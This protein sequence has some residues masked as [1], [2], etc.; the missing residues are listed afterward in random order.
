MKS[1]DLTPKQLEAQ[2]VLAGDAT[3]IMLF[4]G[5]RSGKTFLLVR[6]VV[7]RALKAPK[8]RHAILRFRFNAIKASIVYDTFPKVMEIA[9]PGVPHELNKTDWFAEFDN[10]SQ[11]WFGGL[12][13]KE[14]TEKIL[15]QEYATIYLNETSQIPY[16]SRETAVTRLAQKAEQVIDG[17]NPSP[18]KPRMYYDCNPPSKA[19]WTYKLFV[20]KADPDSKKPLAN[21]HDYAYF[22]IN[23]EDNAE[24]ISA[25]Y[26][27]T[28][29]SLSAAKRRRFLDGQFTDATPNQLFSEDTIEKW[30]HTHGNLPDFVRVVVGVDPSGSGDVE[31]ADN[32]AIGIIV[33]AIGTDGNAYLLEDCTVKAGP[34]TWGSVAVNAYDR[35]ESDALVGEVNYGG[36]MVEHTI[37]VARKNIGGR[38]CNYKSVNATRG[39]V[40]RA[41]PFSALYEQG[42]VRHVG[43][44]PELEEEMAAFS[45]LGYMGERSPNRA[46]AW[47]WV[48]T[49]LFPGLVRQAKKPQ[50]VEVLPTAHRWK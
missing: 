18:L 33:G 6:N 12:D 32:D 45:T 17:R 34:A 24:N 22:Q 11:I 26:L 39:K 48:L 19:H 15:G 13:D 30:R 44:Y 38:S 1:F 7:M 27:E 35:H 4:G 2:H 20:Q 9:F 40:I 37:Q 42:K 50:N 8:S 23:P 31:N 10:G 3:H 16:G 29:Q 21:P 14:R 36:A 47:I 46:D 43:Y 28:L 41:E 5:S 49:E 25:G